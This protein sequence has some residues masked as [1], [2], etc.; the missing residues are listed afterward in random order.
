MVAAVRTMPGMAKKPPKR[1]P[2]RP[3][4]RTP[5]ETIFARVSPDLAKALDSYVSTFRPKT[6]QTAVVEVALEEYLTKHGFWPPAAEPT[7]T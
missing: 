2:G 4:G 3:R 7:A 1:R 5:T 6:T